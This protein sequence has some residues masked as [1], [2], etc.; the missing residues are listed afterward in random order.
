[1]RRRGDWG[2]NGSGVR[3]QRQARGA[4]QEAVLQLDR[5][6]RRHRDGARRRR[7]PRALDA[8]GP[9]ISLLL[10]FA[11]GEEADAA[12]TG[13]LAVIRCESYTYTRYHTVPILLRSGLTPYESTLPMTRLH[14]K[15]PG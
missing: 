3:E 5:L 14:T 8:D 4:G 6:R 10:K 11:I 13:R 9:T 2:K 15:K 12:G 7:R 1:M